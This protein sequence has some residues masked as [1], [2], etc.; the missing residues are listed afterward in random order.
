MGDQGPWIRHVAQAW[1]AAATDAPDTPIPS[2][3]APEAQHDAHIAY[4]TPVLHLLIFGLG[5]TRPDLGLAAWRARRWPLDDP[6]LRVVH[7]WWGEDGV[8]DI[9]AWF[10]MNE[11]I[12]FNLEH[13][14]D[15]HS[16]AQ[17]PREAPFRDTPEF[18]E[19]RRSPEWQAAFGGG[20][21]SLHLTHHLGSPL[22][23]AGPHNPT[24]FDQRWVSAD[25]PNEVPRFTVINDRYEGWYVDFWHYQV[26]LGPN[27]RSV[28]TEVFVRPIGW[29]GEFRQHKT[30]RLWFRGRAAIHMWGQPTQ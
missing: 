11:G 9:L 4:W 6:I 28:R 22:V 19:R 15:A 3:P 13:H 14:V 10:A 26:E 5:W 23:L 18:E 24:F 16:M 7:R 21:D 27:G 1:Q 17:P 20:T 2:R 29:L 25:D 30:T 12:T 8:L